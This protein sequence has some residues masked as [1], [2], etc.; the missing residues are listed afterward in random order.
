[1]NN[2]DY[3]LKLVSKKIKK[4]IDVNLLDK[5]KKEDIKKI[6]NEKNWSKLTSQQ[7]YFDKM[8]ND[9]IFELTKACND[10]IPNMYL[11]T[12]PTGGDYNMRS[13]INKAIIAK[14]EEEA[15]KQF[16]LSDKQGYL[17]ALFHSFEHD[18]GD[19][20][21]K[22]FPQ[23]ETKYYCDQL[24][25]INILPIESLDDYY[26]DYY[27]HNEDFIRVMD[28]FYNDNINTLVPYFLGWTQDSREITMRNIT[29]N[30]YF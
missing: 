28:K 5:L 24:K 19:N 27:D 23:G 15:I 14:N 7:T 1:M 4:C 22:E 9:I 13:I 8:P 3:L 30:E 25:K 17:V 21:T 6:V 10:Q 2:W 29:I 16:I 20:E 12:V 26:E 18:Y 11:I